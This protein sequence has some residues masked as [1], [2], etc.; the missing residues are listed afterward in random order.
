MAVAPWISPAPATFTLIFPMDVYFVRKGQA[1]ILKPVWGLG[2]R[3]DSKTCVPR[4]NAL[5]YE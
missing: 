5:G 3:R 2:Q 1:K 4:T